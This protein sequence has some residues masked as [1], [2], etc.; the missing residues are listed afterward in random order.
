MSE[1][2]NKNGAEEFIFCACNILEKAATQGLK[3]CFIYADCL[4]GDERL[5]D[6]VCVMMDKRAVIRLLK[7]VQGC[8]PALTENIINSDVLDAEYD[9]LHE[10]VLLL[11]ADDFN[12][13]Q[14]LAFEK[15]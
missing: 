8:F 9:L 5:S 1:H 7:H 4:D 15:D 2:E 10:D 14:T 12:T 3:N 11:R 6:T 13:P